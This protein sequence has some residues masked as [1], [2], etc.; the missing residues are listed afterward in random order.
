MLYEVDEFRQFILSLGISENSQTTYPICSALYKLFVNERKQNANHL[1]YTMAFL[2]QECAMYDDGTM[3]DAEEFLVSLFKL[4]EIELSI[5]PPG[6]Q[7]LDLFRGTYITG[8]KFIG[9]QDGSCVNCRNF[10]GS[11]SLET[12]F[13]LNLNMPDIMR[14]QSL[15]DL[16]QNEFTQPSDRYTAKCSSCCRCVPGQGC[17]CPQREVADVKTLITGPKYLLVKLLRYNS[18]GEKNTCF[19]PSMDFFKFDNQDQTYAIQ[20]IMDHIGLSVNAGHWILH[21][22]RQ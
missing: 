14:N 6:M 15:S 11:E 18:R 5:S 16:I 20:C 4:L 10:P 3:H 2:D 8:R 9:S 21:K 1:R 7:I 19:I 22:K 17:V 13:F 12:F